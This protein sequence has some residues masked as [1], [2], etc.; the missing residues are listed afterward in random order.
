MRKSGLYDIHTVGA[1]TALAQKTESQGL[2]KWVLFVKTLK[3]CSFPKDAEAIEIPA[4]QLQRM[5][6]LF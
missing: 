2:I 3:N 4:K 5:V 1:F 6:Q